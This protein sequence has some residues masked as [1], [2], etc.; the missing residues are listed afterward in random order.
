MRSCFSQFALYRRVLFATLSTE[1]TTYSN[2]EHFHSGF[3]HVPFLILINTDVLL[4]AQNEGVK[5]CPQAGRGHV[6]K[7]RFLLEEL[8]L[9]C[10]L[11]PTYT[12]TNRFLRPLKQGVKKKA[13]ELEIRTREAEREKLELEREKERLHS[14]KQI[15]DV[16][17]TNQSM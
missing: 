13:Q 17:P 12:L 14:V 10:P 3:K 1:R 6:G 11:S 15:G 8:P 4:C 7:V 2:K 5:G 16:F 9:S